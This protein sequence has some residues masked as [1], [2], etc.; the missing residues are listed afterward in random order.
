M[1]AAGGD[2]RWNHPGDMAQLQRRRAN[3]MII[4]EMAGAGLHD[5]AVPA[6]ERGDFLERFSFIAVV[7]VAGL[8]AAPP[9]VADLQAGIAAFEAGDAESALALLRP[10]AEGGDAQAQFLLGELL[11][12]GAVP[13][14][15]PAATE[16]YRKAA[17]GGVAG[18]QFQLGMRYSV[19]LGLDQDLVQ[20]YRWLEIAGRSLSTE[21]AS[22]FI[23]TFIGKMNEADIA[24]AKALVAAWQPGPGA[25]PEK[26]PVPKPEPP[27]EVRVLSA[28]A[29]LRAVLQEYPCSDVQV[30]ALGEDRWRLTGY[31]E[32]VADQAALVAAMATAMPTQNLESELQ[33]IGRPVCAAAA[34]AGGFR[35]RDRMA[36]AVV[37]GKPS[38][39]DG[40]IVVVDLTL[41]TVPGYLYVDYYQLDGQVV[42][43]LPLADVAREKTRAGG[44]LR[45]GDGSAGLT[46]R[47]GPPF[48]R[49]MLTVFVVPE[50]LF[51]EP[52]EVIETAETYLIALAER[53][54][55]MAQRDDGQVLSDAVLI[56]TVASR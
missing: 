6:Q 9:A 54:K 32:A 28:E 16:W 11:S 29:T 37:G 15:L 50:P 5:A 47:V 40:E 8:L 26:D 45:L 13:R 31:V 46:L 41:P 52:R 56:T 18:A 53:A 22:Q 21:A 48:G 10:E 35:D 38:F 14:D 2:G 55:Q 36:L 24:E 25:A 4:G 43:I 7:L 12:G 3:V 33:A 23:Q 34:I 20:A 1:P 51:D 39:A 19:G 49:E 17:E 44:N 42:H 27:P 30:I